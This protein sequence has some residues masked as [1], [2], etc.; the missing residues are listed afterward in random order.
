[1]QPP[2]LPSNKKI[3]TTLQRSW[4]R[5]W[6]EL[7]QDKGVTDSIAYARLSKQNC[8]QLKL[9]SQLFHLCCYAATDNGNFGFESVK[10]FASQLENKHSQK[11]AIACIQIF[12]LVKKL[13]HHVVLELFCTK[14]QRRQLSLL[15]NLGKRSFFFKNPLKS[16]I[17]KKI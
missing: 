4:F 1:M 14:R 9:F 12:K 13:S 2:P 6:C 8:S 11:N 17:V 3:C 16:L 15:K 7:R 5:R 10:K